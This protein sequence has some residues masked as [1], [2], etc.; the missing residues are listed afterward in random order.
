MVRTERRRNDEICPSPVMKGFEWRCES[1]HKSACA[2]TGALTLNISGL[3]FG[4]VIR[5][6]RD[7]AAGHSNQQ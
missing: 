4:S 7:E 3:V 5:D 2:S 6:V 1:R